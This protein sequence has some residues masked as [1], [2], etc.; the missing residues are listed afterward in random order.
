[1]GLMEGQY[2]CGACGL[3]PVDAEGQKCAECMAKESSQSTGEEGMTQPENS[4]ASEDFPMNPKEE[5]SQDE[6]SQG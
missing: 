2:M 6:S 5:P 4:S 1:M 3:N